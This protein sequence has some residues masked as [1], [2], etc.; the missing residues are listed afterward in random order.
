MKKLLILFLTLVCILSLTA[1][2]NATETNE[3]VDIIPH[4]TVNG[5][6][7]VSTGGPLVPGMLDG[8]ALAGTIQS[9]TD[10]RAEGNWQAN[11]FSVGTEIWLN[12]DVPYQA[13]IGK[14]HLCVTGEARKRYLLHE[15]ELYVS[16]GDMPS[17]EGDYYAQYNKKFDP[18]EE[19]PADAVELGT[20][21]F[22]MY[23]RYPTNE[24]ESNVLTS[25][26]IIYQDSSDPNVLYALSDGGTASVYIKYI[27]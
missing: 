4:F 13:F 12:P 5:T 26:H 8:F 15:G 23:Y 2:G 3:K 22:G 21:T 27:Q 11:G 9:E 25:P 1:C 14:E 17:Y 24:L 20:S 19:L 18:I 6:T 10:G 16:L 7:Y